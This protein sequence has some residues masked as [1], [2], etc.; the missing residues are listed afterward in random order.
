VVVLPPILVSH[1]KQ[2]VT[3]PLLSMT[4]GVWAKWTTACRKV[5][6]DAWATRDPT[7]RRAVPSRIE[8]LRVVH[9]QRKS[10]PGNVSIGR[11]FANISRVLKNYDFF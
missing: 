1:H 7:L 11:F 5:T 6:R 2:I 9:F 10:M 4:C 3:Y 8:K